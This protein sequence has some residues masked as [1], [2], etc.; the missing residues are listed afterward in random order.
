M[1]VK[2]IIASFGQARTAPRAN[3]ILVR[4]ANESSGAFNLRTEKLIQYLRANDAPDFTLRDRC[5]VQLR[6]NNSQY[7]ALKQNPH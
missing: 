4:R 1:N 3:S 6:S 2:N 7:T 5:F